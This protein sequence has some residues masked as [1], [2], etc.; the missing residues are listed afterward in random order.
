MQH[1]IFN[2][3]SKVFS[4]RTKNSEYQLQV[5]DYG[6]LFHLYYGAPVGDTELAHLVIGADRGASGNPYEA[7]DRRAFSLDL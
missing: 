5:G 6:V 4:L 1:I 2:E 3:Q 7:G